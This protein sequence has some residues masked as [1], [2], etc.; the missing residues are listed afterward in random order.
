MTKILRIDSSARTSESVSRELATR[1]IDRFPG[2]V[3]V[4]T[5]DL[6]DGV[7]LL[8][9]D[10]LLAMWTPAD[11]R[12]S[13]QAGPPAPVTRWR[14]TVPLAPRTSP[15]TLGAGGAVGVQAVL[16]RGRA[17]GRLGR[18]RPGALNVHAGHRRRR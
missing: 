8:S 5:R 14:R 15:G 4:T 12:T 18:G 2:E 13:E 9:E 7:P 11:Q 16:G 3:E 17:L 6:S 1:L 10:T